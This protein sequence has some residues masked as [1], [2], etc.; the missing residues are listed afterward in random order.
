MHKLDLDFCFSCSSCPAQFDSLRELRQ[1]L[2]LR[3]LGSE[4]TN[5]LTIDEFTT[6]QDKNNYLIHNTDESGDLDLT[7]KEIKSE[8]TNT[9]YQGS[10]PHS[11]EP[12][13]Q[14]KLFQCSEKDCV[15]IF[16]YRK[17]LNEHKFKK[18]KLN[19]FQCYE[20][21]C[22]QTFYSTKWLNIHRLKDHK[23]ETTYRCEEC[24]YTA[25]QS[26][27]F[28]RHKSRHKIKRSNKEPF[29]CSECG[30]SFKTILGYK[31][32]MKKKN[33]LYEHKCTKCEFISITRYQLKSHEMK[34]HTHKFP[35]IC[36]ECGKGFTQQIYLKLHMSQH[37]GEKKYNCEFCEA[38]F[39]LKSTMQSHERIHRNIKEFECNMCPKKFRK[40]DNLAVH[41]K[42]HMNQKDHVCSTCDRGFI[43]PAGLRKHKCK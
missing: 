26:I 42:R 16:R 1:H 20:T 18:H 10:A 28:S 32:H 33:S 5:C 23:L 24:S 14:N 35:V 31:Y 27:H 43:E 17:G 12:I 13:D 8:K 30:E 22:V 7:K 21:D 38:V 6:E 3:F 11:N 39:R 4:A 34:K 9:K 15:K 40:G 41:I 36:S 29:V 2:C 19:L 25:T 37:T